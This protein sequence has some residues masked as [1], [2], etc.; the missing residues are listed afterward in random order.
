MGHK[1]L[2]LLTVASLTLCL[3]AN[4]RSSGEREESQDG[5]QRK[6][7]YQRITTLRMP[8]QASSRGK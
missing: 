4:V 5:H 2:S 7:R 1:I 8:L 3:L 6:Q